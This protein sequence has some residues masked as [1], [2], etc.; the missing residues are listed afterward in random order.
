MIKRR[1]RLRENTLD[2]EGKKQ[3]RGKRL[4]KEVGGKGE[5]TLCF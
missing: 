3:R 5:N 4:K 1:E 2:E